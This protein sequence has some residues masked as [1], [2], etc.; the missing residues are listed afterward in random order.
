MRTGNRLKLQKGAFEAQ[1]NMT[2]VGI[3]D[4]S[5]DKQSS[6]ES[7]VKAD[8]ILLTDEQNTGNYFNDINVLKEPSISGSEDEQEEG[9]PVNAN[10]SGKVSLSD[11]LAAAKTI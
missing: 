9:A 4:L 6:I 2:T 5:P 7:P 1:H 8:K 11:A 3:E 10:S